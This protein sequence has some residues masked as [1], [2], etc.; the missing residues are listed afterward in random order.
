MVKKTSK[1]RRNSSKNKQPAKKLKKAKQNKKLAKPIIKKIVKKTIKKI[2]KKAAPKK[3]ISAQKVVRPKQ[4]KTTGS[5]L[6]TGIPGF[7]G[8]VERGITKGAAILLCGGPGTGKTTFALQTLAVSAKKGEKCLYLTFEEEPEKLLSH[9][10]D[11]G[12]KPTELQKKD[13]FRI[14]K[15]DA[16][17]LNRSVEALL[18][19]ASGELMIELDE[20]E[21]IIPKGFKPD[22]IVVD[23]LSAVAA[24]FFG[25]EQGYRVYLQQLFDLFKRVGATSFFISE[26]DEDTT[27]FSR[28]GVE[29]F[30][31]DGVFVFYNIRQKSARVNALEIIK[32][33]GSPH[34]K[35]IVPFRIQTGSGIIV[36]PLEEVFTE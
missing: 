36:Y 24:A 20:V 30:L 14:K 7:D 4:Q 3:I 1:K 21:G 16:F 18:A 35:K 33:R 26:I 6:Q 28:S 11:Y 12:F 31:A 9:M 15:F 13:L 2:I 27:R 19:K 22:R 23:S 17:D 29:E 32:L 8:L 25:K 10:Q 5:F 34:Q